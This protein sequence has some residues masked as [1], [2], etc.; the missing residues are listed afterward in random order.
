MTT[1][2]PDKWH[3]NLPTDRTERPDMGELV[4]RETEGL[5]QYLRNR[6][7][8]DSGGVGTKHRDTGRLPLKPG[9][10]L[11]PACEGECVLTIFSQEGYAMGEE[12]CDFCN[13]I[14][15]VVAERSDF[16]QY[17]RAKQHKLKYHK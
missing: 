5:R 1:S 9:W 12:D 6:G 16:A 10:K 4:E 17:C 2:D 13:A 14:G 11:C 8:S 15:I 7:I 3:D